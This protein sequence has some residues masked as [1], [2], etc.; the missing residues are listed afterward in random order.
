MSKSRPAPSRRLTCTD[1]RFV[2]ADFPRPVTPR[3]VLTFDEGLSILLEK[4]ADIDLACELVASLRS[5]LDRKGG[6]P[7]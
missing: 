2:E 4:P 6:R 5:R 3:L 1:I 7:C